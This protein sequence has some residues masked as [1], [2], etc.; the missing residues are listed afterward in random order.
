LRFADFNAALNGVTNLETR[1]GSFL[2][3]VRGERFDT[4]VCNP[5]Y[6]IS[7]EQELTY[8]DGPIRGD[9]LSEQLVRE[10]PDIL[11][12]NGIAS[13]L[14]SWVPKSD[15]VTAEPVSWAI[16]SSCAA[17][18]FALHH[19]TPQKASEW[20]LGDDQVSV[21]R[22]LRWYAAEGIER[23]AYGAVV[24][25]RSASRWV[26]A[27]E[28]PGGPA[29]PAGDQLERL[30]TGR[31]HAPQAPVTWAPDVCRDVTREGIRLT[32]ARGL[33]IQV[34]LTSDVVPLV[35]AL[36][37][38]GTTEAAVAAGPLDPIVGE[39]IVRRLLELGLLVYR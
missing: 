30:F 22:W 21:E 3:P 31:E 20:W 27:L 7:P 29:G 39:Q 35:E 5:P 19:D 34:D 36:G 8:R 12:T 23:L 28:L 2:E 9:R 13:V 37:R 24:M 4:V 15:D 33:P 26:D 1:L 17:W 18:V 10:I 32:F 11:E 14:V 38:G 6:V 16:A 25:K